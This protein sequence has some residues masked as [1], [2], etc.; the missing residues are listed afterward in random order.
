MHAVALARDADPDRLSFTAPSGWRA[1]PR[2][3]TRV[4]PPRALADARAKAAGEILFEVLPKRRLRANPRVV[5]RKMSNYGVKRSGHRSHPQPTRAPG[6]A[7]RVRCP[8][9]AE[10]V[11]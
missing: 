5:K 6:D 9:A 4:F 10:E 7:V 1:G 3:R 11:T 2:R 8:E